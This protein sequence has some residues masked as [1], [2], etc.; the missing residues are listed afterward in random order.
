MD[1]TVYFFFAES[2]TICGCKTKRKER[3][4]GCFAYRTVGSTL[5]GPQGAGQIRDNAGGGSKGRA[6]YSLFCGAKS[7]KEL[8]DR[9]G[10]AL[11]T[12]RQRQGD[13]AKMRGK[14]EG[15]RGKQF[16]PLAQLPYGP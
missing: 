6:F 11:V 1:S 12:R 4:F 15:G 14:K 5:Y 10:S 9:P 7:T 3:G 8:W 13:I 2:V 16:Y